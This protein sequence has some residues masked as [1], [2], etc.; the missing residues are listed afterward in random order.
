MSRGVLRARFL[1]HRAGSANTAFSAARRP[2]PRILLLDTLRGLALLNMLVYHFLYDLVS[3]NG[4]ELPWY[5]GTPGYLWEQYICWSFI[6][7]AGMSLHFS[8]HPVRHGL[9]TFGCGAAV[10][11]VTAVAT[12]ADAVH[13]GVLTLLGSAM[14]LTC[15][16][17]PMLRHIP[18]AAGCIL[19]GAVFVL[20]KALPSGG[21]G[22]LNF[23]LWPLPDA[24]YSVYWLYPF[25]FH[26]AWFSSSD[27]FPLLP[28]FFLFL[29]GY[30]LWEWCGKAL[31][32]SRAA[33]VRIPVL[34]R[35]GQNTLW[36]YMVHQPILYGVSM[37]L[38]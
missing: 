16:L 22:I 2:K 26:T 37:L 11:L 35:L 17:K 32:A 21:F 28:W 31:A 30:F 13:F 27:Y 9:I 3:F 23:V 1:P 33:G 25:G 15:A 10:S 24:W 14:L 4:V 8:R 19:S 7:L 34:T 5:S 38:L 6:L 20:T 36:I 12:P 29:T 18:A